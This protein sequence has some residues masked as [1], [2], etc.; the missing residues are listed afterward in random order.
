[1]IIR[2]PCLF[3]A[4]L[5]LSGCVTAP[6]RQ[7]DNICDIFSEKTSWYKAAH[8]SYERWG[9]PIP[10]QM[11]FLYQESGFV[12]NAKPPRKRLLGFIPWKRPSTARGY[13]QALNQ[14][15]S[16]YKKD[17]GRTFASRKSF[18]DATDFVGWYIDLSYRQIGLSK[19]DAYSHYLAY[20]EGQGGFKRGAY[21]N[22]PWLLNVAGQVRARSARYTAQLRTCEAE[23]QRSWWKFW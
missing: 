1:M 8:K 21:R 16:R 4:L 10:V 11:A 12:G 20:Y 3:L 23:L 17:T 7:A 18:A 6:P 15:W 19:T 14:T 2:L 22:K 5:M 13:S 9:A